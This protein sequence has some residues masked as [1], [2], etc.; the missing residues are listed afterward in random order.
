MNNETE[1]DRVKVNDGELLWLRISYLSFDATN[2]RVD[3]LKNSESGG[4]RLNC[5]TGRRQSGSAS[6][7]QFGKE[8][9]LAANHPSSHA[10]QTRALDAV[11]T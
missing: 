7:N 9:R 1:G 6:T 5:G 8:D 2:P 3:A 4:A 10:V 11:T